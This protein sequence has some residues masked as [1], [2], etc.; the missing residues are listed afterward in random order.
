[1]KL[2]LFMLAGIAATAIALQSYD[3][4]KDWFKA[5]SQPGKY[6]MGIDPG[7]GHDGK[8]CATIK[9][10]SSKIRGF[11]TLMQTSLP[12][13]YLGKRVRM[14]GY[15]KAENVDKWAGFWLRVD[16]KDN[17]KSSAF[18]NMS[19]R[20]V[21][22]TTDWKKYEIVLDVSLNAKDIAYGCLLAGTGQVWFDDIQFE[23]VGKD[24]PVTGTGIIKS[25]EEPSNLNFEK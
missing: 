13:K 14:S 8:N 24:V 19:D 11:G 6:E 2:K 23:V 12:D 15:M 16:K 18:D 22:G 4:P 20:P 9:S 7:K 17:D 10:T 5:G 21:K 3:L 1:M 25:V